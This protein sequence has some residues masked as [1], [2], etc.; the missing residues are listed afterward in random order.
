M[1]K[2]ILQKRIDKYNEKTFILID[3]ICK[4]LQ[5]INTGFM[6][7]L[8]YDNVTEFE[9]FKKNLESLYQHH[10]KVEYFCDI[11]NQNGVIVE[12]Y[13]VLHQLLPDYPKDKQIRIK[14]IEKYD[15]LYFLDITSILHFAN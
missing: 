7:D 11:V 12:Q 13:Q 5:I 2:E 8:Y 14:W 10:K 1:N 3:K 4:N 9:D 6:A 15:L